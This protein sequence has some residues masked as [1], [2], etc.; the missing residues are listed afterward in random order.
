MLKK[1]SQKGDFILLKV[2]MY[3]YYF[4]F[5]VKANSSACFVESAKNFIQLYAYF[6]WMDLVSKVFRFDILFVMPMTEGL[7]I[8]INSLKV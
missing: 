2:Q 1:K 7:C 5:N 8:S 4:I 3:T 6:T